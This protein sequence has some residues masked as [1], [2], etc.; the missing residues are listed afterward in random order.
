MVVAVVV[1]ALSALRFGYRYFRYSR[2]RRHARTDGASSALL[3]GR[4]IR[5]GERSIQGGQSEGAVIRLDSAGAE[6][7]GEE[8]IATD[9][10]APRQSLVDGA[11][12]ALGVV[13]SNVDSREVG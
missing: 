4:Q 1:F 10:G 5:I 6:V 11:H 3:I 8:E 9:V 13:D 2:V 7:S 12:T